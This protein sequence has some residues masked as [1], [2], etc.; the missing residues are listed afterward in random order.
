M[1]SD[2]GEKEMELDDSSVGEQSPVASGSSEEHE[3][4]RCSV[5]RDLFERLTSARYDKRKLSNP[6]RFSVTGEKVL[7]SASTCQDCRLI[8]RLFRTFFW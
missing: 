1:S 3:A 4:P 7:K 5:C 2:H 6:L 8:G